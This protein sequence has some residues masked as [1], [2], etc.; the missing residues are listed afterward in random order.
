MEFIRVITFS[1][2]AIIKR[3]VYITGDSVV[4]YIICHYVTGLIV[5]GINKVII[6]SSKVINNSITLLV[7]V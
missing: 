6:Y 2:K 5:S 4:Y 3:Y 1:R 7:I